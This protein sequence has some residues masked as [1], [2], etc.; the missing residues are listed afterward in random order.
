[1]GMEHWERE[2]VGLKNISLISNSIPLPSLG[3]YE[4]LDINYFPEYVS[5]GYLGY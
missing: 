2:G 5:L 4:Y 3:P 1:M